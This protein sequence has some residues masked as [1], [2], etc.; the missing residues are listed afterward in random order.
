MYRAMMNAGTYIVRVKAEN[1][2]E[3]SIDGPDVQ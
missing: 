1:A 3:L 2:A